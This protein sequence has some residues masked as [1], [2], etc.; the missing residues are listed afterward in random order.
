VNKYGLVR[1]VLICPRDLE[2]Y[3]CDMVQFGA[4]RQGLQSRNWNSWI[5]FSNYHFVL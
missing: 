5:V 3:Y 2:Q 4:T 1:A